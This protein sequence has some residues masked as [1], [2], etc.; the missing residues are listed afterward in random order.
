MGI[1]LAFRQSWALGG[2]LVL[3]AAAN[4]AFFLSYGALDTDSMVL[5]LYVVWA[6]WIGLGLHFV[7]VLAYR[8]GGWIIGT[9]LALILAGT[10]SFST[11]WSFRLVDLSEDWSVRERGEVYSRSARCRRGHFSG[12]GPRRR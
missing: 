4:T 12:R 6:I 9:C 7:L 10:V 8:H 2:M 11:A 1:G 3:I 5:P